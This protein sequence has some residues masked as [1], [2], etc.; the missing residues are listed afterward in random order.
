MTDQGHLGVV[1]VPL[2]AAVCHLLRRSRVSSGWGSVTKFRGLCL[3]K[4]PNSGVCASWRCHLSVSRAVCIH[5]T[6]LE[7]I[8]FHPCAA[9]GM[10]SVPGDTCT[11]CHFEGNRHCVVLN[12]QR[13]P[14]PLS[15]CFNIT[16]SASFCVPWQRQSWK[17]RVSSSAVP[18][19]L[20]TRPRLDASSRNNNSGRVFG[21][22]SLLPWRVWM[23]WVIT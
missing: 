9:P 18:H 23:L 5:C 22:W 3:L 17:L 15:L 1:T 20:P 13:P 7:G 12:L 16:F 4:V 14:L 2:I 8:P 6:S 19:S 21:P 10:L 11:W